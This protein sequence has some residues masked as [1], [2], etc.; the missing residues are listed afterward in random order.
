MKNIDSDLQKKNIKWWDQ[1]PMNYDWNKT[2]EESEGT[3]EFF[4]S[5][6]ERFFNALKM[7][8]H[9]KYPDQLPFS[10]LI[11]YRSLAGKNVLE[12]GCGHGSNKN[13]NRYIF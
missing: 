7:F 4:Q 10:E 1:N 5:I 9:P 8:A 12:V 3:K 11:D 6:D 13:I 2:L